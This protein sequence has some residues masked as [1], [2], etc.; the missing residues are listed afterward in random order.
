MQLPRQAYA[1]L[2]QQNQHGGQLLLSC[3]RAAHSKLRMLD[4]VKDAI[5]WT[6]ARLP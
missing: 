2:L 4:F 3:L 6:A 5:P 1:A